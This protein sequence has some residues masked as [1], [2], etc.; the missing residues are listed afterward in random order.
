MKLGIVA[1]GSVHAKFEDKTL[2]L[3]VS[4][5]ILGQWCVHVVLSRDLYNVPVDSHCLSMASLPS[6]NTEK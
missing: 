1:S 2:C 3:L 5:C 4:L 6:E